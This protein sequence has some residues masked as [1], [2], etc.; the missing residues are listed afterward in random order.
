M[1][2]R[3]KP[4]QRIRYEVSALKNPTGTYSL[5]GTVPINL[6]Y[7][8][9]DGSPL[10]DDMARAIR[11]VGP[12]MYLRSGKIQ[13]VLFKS[14]KSAMAAYRKEMK[15]IESA[16]P[17]TPTPA[18]KMMEDDYDRPLSSHE[19]ADLLRVTPAELRRRYE[20]GELKVAPD[21]RTF[22]IAPG[23]DTYALIPSPIVVNPPKETIMTTGK[24]DVRELV[25]KIGVAQDRQENL[26]RRHDELVKRAMKTKDGRKLEVIQNELR[27]QRQRIDHTKE[28][29]R[30]LNNRMSESLAED[31]QMRKPAK[32]SYADQ[33]KWKRDHKAY[34]ARDP[35][36]ETGSVM[37]YK[38]V[39]NSWVVKRY[40]KG[41]LL[42]HTIRHD[43]NGNPIKTLKTAK[44]IAIEA[45]YLEDSLR[46]MT[47]PKDSDPKP[48]SRP[49]R[50]PVAAKPMRKVG[51]KSKV[52]A[53]RKTDMKERK[54]SQRELDNILGI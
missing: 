1:A 29:I 49:K 21:G 5:V 28:K 31:R 46:N 22:E 42:F 6:S 2:R 32:P 30:A 33:I 16:P 54:L 7:T 47:P 35:R 13:N 9:A 12:G 8:M 14:E 26:Q 24:T 44:V 27:I 15:R 36:D 51:A 18:L 41:G 38:G 10:T 39:G 11:H 37:V 23:S 25:R 34:M 52:K 43:G 50:K 48:M 4:V 53:P 20:A 3:R 45:L 40:D 17:P 19:A